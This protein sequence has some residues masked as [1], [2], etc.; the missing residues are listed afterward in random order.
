MLSPKQERQIFLQQN[1][2]FDCNCRPCAE[3]WP[4]LDEQQWVKLFIYAHLLLKLMNI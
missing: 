3:N 2:G 1:F 4:V